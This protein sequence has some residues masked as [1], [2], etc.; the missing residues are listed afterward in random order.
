MSRALLFLAAL[1]LAAPARA[2][3]PEFEASLLE[4]R[5]A[6][7]SR[8]ALQRASAPVQ[9]PPTL[10]KSLGRAADAATW[11]ALL[12]RARRRPTKTQTVRVDAADYKVSIVSVSA[13]A[14]G[15]S[16]P[17]GSTPLNTVYLSEPVQGTGRDLYPVRIAAACAGP[18]GKLDSFTVDADRDG[19][20]LDASVMDPARGVVV[21][22][23]PDRVTRDEASRARTLLDGLIQLF[24]A[25]P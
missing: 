17:A 6:V 9:K 4:M 2:A 24:L 3:L 10:V 22:S 8:P 19:V 23:G 7:L 20:V 11:S 16:C 25:A 21:K 18:A 5:G 12:D 13:P 14:Q 15:Q 1:S